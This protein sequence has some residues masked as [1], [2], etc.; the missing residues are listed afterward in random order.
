MK[1][2][3][4]LRLCKAFGAEYSWRPEW[5]LLERFYIRTFG[6]VDLPSRFRARIVLQSIRELQAKTFLDFGSGTGCYSFYL[7][8]QP[9]VR[10]YSMDRDTSRINDCRQIASRTGQKNMTFLTGS[11]HEGL[12]SLPSGCSDMVLAVE[13]LQYVPDP[14]LS[15]REIYRLLTP[16]GHLVG[17]LPVLGYLRESEHTLFDD[18]VIQELLTR[19]GFEVKSIIPTFGGFIRQLCGVFEW[20]SKSR[21]IVGLSFP[22]LMLASNFC[23]VASPN[24]AYRMFIAQ[25]PTKR[26]TQS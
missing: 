11:G 12:K 25:K 6:V 20:L 16:G 13:V 19:A 21:L 24:G 23:D 7:A 8:R 3:D 15:L 1:V 22:F 2:T 5:N 18:G 14:T 17:H 10:V 26:I 4:L 9:A